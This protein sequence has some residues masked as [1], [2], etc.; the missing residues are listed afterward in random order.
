MPVSF[1]MYIKINHTSA[2]HYWEYHH[3]HYGDVMSVLAAQITGNS[4]VYSTVRTGLHKRK[5]HWKLRI[6]CPLRGEEAVT[7]G[8]GPGFARKMHQWPGALALLWEES[9][10]VTNG[11]PSQGASNA[12]NVFISWSW[13]HRAPKWF[14]VPLSG[15]PTRNT[16]LF[17]WLFRL[18]TLQPLRAPG[19]CRRPSGRAIGRAD[20][21]R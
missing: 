7:G 10:A 2:P 21:P 13:R 3:S 17:S 1:Y 18:F 4:I 11:F 12:E 6:T 9:T 20:K 16:Q 14:R 15:V 5:H 19:Y 8:T